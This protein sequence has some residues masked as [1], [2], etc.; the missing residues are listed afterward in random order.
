MKNNF[1]SIRQRYEEVR[2]E[3]NRYVPRWNEISKYV[4]IKVEP[5]DYLQAQSS[6][7]EDLDKFTE[8][9]TAA[10]SVQQSADYLKGIMWG[11]GEG[12]F[13]LLP[14]DELLEIIDND[15][16]K[17]W[18]EY[19][20]NKSLNEMNH[21][22]AGLNSAL[23]AYHYDQSSYGTSG[24]G[25]FPNGSYGKGRDENILLFRPY[26]ID[27]LAIDEGKNG[28]ID[29]VFNAYSWRTNR[30][31]SE[32][33]DKEEGFAKDMFEKLPQK[34]KSAY[35]AK[36]FNQVFK[37]VQAILPREDFEPGKL[38]AK[39]C[40]YI[41]YWF[42]EEDRES[43]FYEED[44]KERPIPICRA[45]KIRG[46]IY[47]R[48]A[49]T[50]LLST[51]RCVNEIVSN[52]MVTL[53]KMENPPIG[54]LHSALLGDDVLDTSPSGLTVFNAALMNGN[55]PVFP[56]QDIGD[57]SAIIQFLLPYLNEKVATA[58]K[59]DI[60]LDFSSS[61]QMTAT[62]SLQR[63]SIRGRSIAGLITQQKT[64]LYEPLIKRSVSILYDRNALGINPNDGE[65]VNSLRQTGRAERII[66]A[67]VIQLIKE[68]KPWYRIKFNN[69][70]EKLT[71]TE[72]VED[73]L[74]MLNVIG[75]MMGL[76]PQIATAIDWHS[77]LADVSE[78][79]G[80]SKLIMSKDK[81]QEQLE[82][83]AQAQMAMMTSQ[84]QAQESV[85][86]KNNASA[87]KEINNAQ[88]V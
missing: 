58:F 12:V 41:G 6:K 43:F 22:N 85:A 5:N 64:E 27:T 18:F 16:V 7:S 84:M 51:I 30:F 44:Y 53:E 36:D 14:S 19:A 83:Q 77:L 4:G 60:L 23:S 32:F 88:A 56:V 49:G 35:K 65:K 50:M 20:T 78:A 46:E 55:P 15:A 57:P 48:G 74:K 33:C 38:G 47:G 59:I 8:D 26:G 70:V 52:L 54:I 68:G 24:V 28:L 82:A 11:T 63:F 13:S 31:V 17:D 34:V 81:F 73:L 42:L 86:N 3:R 29:I 40:K 79:L 61:T 9:P 71:K 66:P 72:R 37:L 1:A 67:Q 87:L 25:C 10:I 45:E 80:M 39:G 62:E 69:E 76:Y 21:S 2:S 75:A